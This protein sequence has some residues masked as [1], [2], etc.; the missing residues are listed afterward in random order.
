MGLMLKLS[1]QVRT[2]NP[3][4]TGKRGTAW[5]FKEYVMA[6][7]HAQM[8][9]LGGLAHVTIHV[10]SAPRHFFNGPQTTTVQCLLRTHSLL[11]TQH[12]HLPLGWLRH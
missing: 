11:A 2:S 4:T 10:Y 7:A 3:T 5:Y 1:P 6:E 12:T 8:C 9:T